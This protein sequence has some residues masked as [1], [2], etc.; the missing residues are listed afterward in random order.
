MDNFDM[1]NM[2]SSLHSRPG[3]ALDPPAMNYERPRIPGNP[4]ATAAT[5]AKGH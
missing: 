5:T 3:H 1:K 2:H 4:R